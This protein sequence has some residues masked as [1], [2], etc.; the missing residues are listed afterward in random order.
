[1][2]IAKCIIAGIGVVLAILFIGF[3]GKMETHYTRDGFVAE[4]NEGITTIEDYTGNLWDI[5]ST[6]FQI[7]DNVSLLLIDNGTQELQD[8]VVEDVI[9]R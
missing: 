6:E 9:Y 4:V 1:M 3:V 5:E 2:N 8:D 7:G